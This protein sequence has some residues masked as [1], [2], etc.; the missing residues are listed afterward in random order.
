MNS[1]SKRR[2]VGGYTSVYSRCRYVHTHGTRT[3]SR[4]ARS[5]GPKDESTY[6]TRDEISKIA[7][8]R[9][10]IAYLDP[11]RIYSGVHRKFHTK[12]YLIYETGKWKSVTDLEDILDNELGKGQYLCYIHTIMNCSFVDVPPLLSSHDSVDGCIRD[13]FHRYIKHFLCNITVGL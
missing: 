8:P 12:R 3:I 2:D 4:S 1:R 11:L 7:F 6:E 10:I 5:S 9:I 13:T